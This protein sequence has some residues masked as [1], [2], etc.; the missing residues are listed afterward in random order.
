MSAE[1]L[2][3]YRCGAVLS[4]LP[5]P[6]SRREECPSCRAELH[7]CRMC[8]HYAPRLARACDEDDAPDVRDKESANFCDYFRPSPD[9]FDGSRAAADAAAQAE[10]ARLFGDGKDDSSAGGDAGG[11]DDETARAL[12]EAESLFKR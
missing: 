12:R 4:G 11:V 6:L 9:A 10:L 3:C 7:V 8:V 5:L 1:D 2:Y